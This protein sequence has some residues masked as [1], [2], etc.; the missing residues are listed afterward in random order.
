MDTLRVW[1]G[2]TDTSLPD[3]STPIGGAIASP[4]SSDSNLSYFPS[5]S[6]I[7]GAVPSWV[8]FV[9]SNETAQQENDCFPSLSWTQRIIGFVVLL[10]IG[11]MFCAFVRQ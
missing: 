1:T 8:P 11:I 9:N 4:T 6:S 2:G 10:L 3:F 5:V 7:R